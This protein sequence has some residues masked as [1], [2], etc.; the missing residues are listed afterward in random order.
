MSFNHLTPHKARK[1]HRCD[2]C[3]QIIHKGE[4]YIRNVGHYDDFYDAKWHFECLED[5]NQ[6]GEYE[7]HPGNGERPDY[8]LT[9]YGLELYFRKY[10][11]NEAMVWKYERP[12][13]HNGF[14]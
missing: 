6:S 3:S 7:W 10:K 1:N 9:N 2:W 11:W 8:R 5:F 14:L 4:L 12:V 13:V